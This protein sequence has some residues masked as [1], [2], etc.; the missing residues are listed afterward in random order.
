MYNPLTRRSFLTG[1]LSTLT[2]PLLVS[3]VPRASRALAA[4]QL[5]AAATN[6]PK[7]FIVFYIPNGLHP[8]AFP[9][10]GVINGVPS[11][12]TDFALPPVLAPLA[13]YRSSMLLMNS[14]ANIAATI[15]GNGDHARGT[16]AMLTCTTAAANA[17]P[18]AN[19]SIDQI[20][21]NTLGGS[22]PI[23]SLQL[24]TDPSDLS[25][26]CDL[27]YS[28]TYTSVLSWKD[29]QT[30][31]TNLTSAAAMF[32]RMFGGSGSNSPELLG[33]RNSMLDYATQDIQLLNRGLQ[34]ADQQKLDEYLTGLRALEQQINFATSCS[35]GGTPVDSPVYGN[36]VQQM[37]DTLVLGLKCNI[38]PVITFMLGNGQSNRTYSFLN[39]N[40]QP[41]SDG[42]H[43]L[44]HDGDATDTYNQLAL[45]ETWE[46]QQFAY[47]IS[48]L[49][50]T[51]DTSGT[52]Y[53]NTLLMLS[54]ELGHGEDHNHTNLP[55]I[56]AGGAHTQSVFTP[57]R[58]VQA[59]ANTPVS[60]LY[61]SLLNNYTPTTS[62]MD[63]NAALSLL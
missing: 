53:D 21:A 25:G 10:D 28:C 13:P 43:T 52:L 31:L 12:S 1:A 6:P 18:V 42:H 46:M 38:S 36:H 32:K 17:T 29:S 37:L 55:V 30:P 16:C 58:Y 48:R 7:R 49:Q 56:L 9:N 44:T 22:Y 54:S 3:A 14:L 19:T 63:S 26:Q 4:R 45:L 57:G 59:A 23:A 47:L 50:S 27:N 33:Q 51:P 5:D 61:V 41:L 35:A 62:F 15:G 40:G 11:G 8:G 39:Y 2:L 34:A 60:N 20:I 24:G